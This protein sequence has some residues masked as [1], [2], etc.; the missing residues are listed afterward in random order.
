MLHLAYDWAMVMSLNLIFQ[1]FCVFLALGISWIGKLPDTKREYFDRFLY[2]AASSLLVGFCTFRN[3]GIA[4]DD[5]DYAGWIYTFSCPTLE[6]GE[7]VQSHLNRDHVWYSLVGLIK[8]FYSDPSIVLWIAGLALI[9]KLWVIDRL[10]RHRSLALLFYVALFYLIHDITALR[11]SLAISIYLLGFYAL[12]EG[13]NK[14]GTGFLVMNGFFHKQAFLAPLLIVGRWLFLN[15]ERFSK[16][17]LIPVSLLIMGLYPNKWILERLMSVSFGK[18]TL[19]IMAGSGVSYFNAMIKG[20]YDQVRTWPVVVPPTLFLAIWLSKDIYYDKPDLYRYASVSLMIATWLLW[21]CGVIPDVQLRFWHFFLVPMVFFIGNAYLTSWRMAAVFGLILIYVL[22]YTFMHDLLLDAPLRNLR[23][24][25]S[26]PGG[27]I[28]I[29]SLGIPCEDHCGIFF[30]EG[31]EVVLTAFAEKGYRFERWTGGC[32]TAKILHCKLP[33]VA[34]QTVGV[35]FKPVR[36]LSLSGEG[37]GVIDYRDQGK[38]KSCKLP[39]VITVDEGSEVELHAKPAKG[40]RLQS[41]SG[42]CHGTDSSCKLIMTQ[43]S[44]A[45][46]TFMKVVDMTL[47]TSIGGKIVGDTVLDVECQNTCNLNPCG[48]SEMANDINRLNPR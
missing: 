6:C 2:Y 27:R 34:D 47:T 18:S 39:C 19:E 16:T 31:T 11:V 46:V 45:T 7:I 10:C 15:P 44:S 43:D 38:D 35:R 32:E 25:D 48:Q 36:V 22:K 3:L 4:L 5:P 9:I 40:F 28:V 24:E 13:R 1:I 21:L 17:L 29:K 42:S 37:M 14:L 12:V 26:S 30:P 23:I 20:A 33:M 41:W 8:S